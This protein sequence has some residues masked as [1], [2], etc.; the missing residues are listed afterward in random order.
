MD[1]KIRK[2]RQ[3]EYPLLDDF[4]YEA[5]FIPDGVEPPPKTIINSPDLQVYVAYFGESKDDLG[6]IAE[7]DGK[8]AGAVW[9]RIMNDYGHIDNETPSLAISLYKEYRGFGIGTAMMK[10]ML[11]LLKDHG[12]K[13][14][15]LSVQKANYAARMY[16][17]IG[18]EIVRENEEEY[19]MVYSL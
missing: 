10:E 11:A 18:F 17:K 4:L 9:V 6:L 13:Q 16:R 15:S 8:I 14:V 19:I 2:I 12:Y 3:Q 1:Y 7:A 5:I